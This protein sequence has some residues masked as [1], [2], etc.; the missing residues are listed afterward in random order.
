MSDKQDSPKYPLDEQVT[1]LEVAVV[2][3]G[4][5]GAVSLGC[6]LSFFLLPSCRGSRSPAKGAGVNGIVQ[7]RPYC[8]CS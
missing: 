2:G 3:A 8:L 6:V 4:S 1:D 5:M 7:S